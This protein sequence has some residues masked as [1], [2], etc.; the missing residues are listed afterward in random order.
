[1]EELSRLLTKLKLDHLE[2]QL[3]TLCEQAAQYE[4]DYQSFRSVGRTRGMN[5]AG[6]GKGK[7]VEFR[8]DEARL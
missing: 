8:G 3:D 6:Q 5:R 4:L 7:F 1:M 2:A